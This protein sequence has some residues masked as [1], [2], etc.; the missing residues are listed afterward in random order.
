M[1]TAES[2]NEPKGLPLYDPP[3]ATPVL[4][5]LKL[6]AE[7]FLVGA[8]YAAR[9]GAVQTGP[10]SVLGYS[11]AGLV[12]GTVN[13]AKPLIDRTY[14]E[15]KEWL[16]PPEP[17]QG[18]D[19]RD[20]DHHTYVGEYIFGKAGD[21]EDREPVVPFG[22]GDQW[23]EQN[24]ERHAPRDPGV[25]DKYLEPE[26]FSF[27]APGANPEDPQ[28]QLT[29]A[30]RAVPS[31]LDRSDRDTSSFGEGG[32]TAAEAGT[33]SDFGTNFGEPDHQGWA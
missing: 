32:H 1:E 15:V 28:F 5:T 24:G 3:D 25:L 27:D 11:G 12:G 20:S 19:Y 26:K 33:P 6:F 30:D 9:S 7:G 10:T 18:K 22:G 2:P 21:G 16:N 14:Q 8:G 17:V 31:E 4:D 23:H 13:A 29:E